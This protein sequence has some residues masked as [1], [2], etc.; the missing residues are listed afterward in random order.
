MNRATREI[1]AGVDGLQRCRVS[2]YNNTDRF[3]LV[4]LPTYK[5]NIQ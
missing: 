3:N 5:V 4:S 2:V 1:T